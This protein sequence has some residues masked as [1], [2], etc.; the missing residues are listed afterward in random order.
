MNLHAVTSVDDHAVVVIKPW[1]LPSPW[2]PQDV[3]LSEL[4]GFKG[5]KTPGSASHHIHAKK[6]LTPA[7]F[8][9]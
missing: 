1:L 9:L 6:M 5:C 7:Y 2:S 4:S 3:H 8:Q